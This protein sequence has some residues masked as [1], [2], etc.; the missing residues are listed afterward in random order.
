MRLWISPGLVAFCWLSLSWA[1]DL[2]KSVGATEAAKK[3]N[4]D[5]ILQM[6]V[7]SANSAGRRLLPQL[8]G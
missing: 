4:E 2:T 8:G 3:A 6:E 7:Y 5:E 1:E